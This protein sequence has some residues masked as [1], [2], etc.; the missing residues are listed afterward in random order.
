MKQY[1]SR[2]KNQVPIDCEIGR[3]KL[4]IFNVIPG[5]CLTTNN[6]Y[7]ALANKKNQRMVSMRNIKGT[8]KEGMV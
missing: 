3:K 5:D 4:I 1:M 8:K 6:I 7:E 2:K